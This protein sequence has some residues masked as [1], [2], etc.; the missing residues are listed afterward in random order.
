MEASDPAAGN[1]TSVVEFW[2]FPNPAAVAT[3]MSDT[4][5]IS[6]TFLESE[7]TFQMGALHADYDSI[8]SI[9]WSRN[10]RLLL[11]GSDNEPSG[12][13]AQTDEYKVAYRITRLNL[14][15]SGM[16]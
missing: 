15:D 4:D 8:L 1:I 16:S 7:A 5:E 12:G 2:P 13:E 6:I 9:E 10:E 3:S 11:V 14:S